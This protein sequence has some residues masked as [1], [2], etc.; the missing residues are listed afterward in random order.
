MRAFEGSTLS[1]PVCVAVT[2][3]GGEVGV[4]LSLSRLLLLPTEPANREAAATSINLGQRPLGPSAG[5]QHLVRQKPQASKLLEAA[6]AYILPSGRED[7]FVKSFA[8]CSFI[9]AT[10]S[11][12]VFLI[13]WQKQ[14][15]EI[16][17]KFCLVLYNTSFR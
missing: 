13:L 9:L 16:P 4:S 3:G 1:V 7:S 14:P 12:S 15:L 17:T 10:E 2:L 6:A 11:P 8:Q 5:L